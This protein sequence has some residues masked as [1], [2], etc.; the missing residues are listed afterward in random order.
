VRL[1]AARH[2][3]NVENELLRVQ[4]PGLHVCFQYDVSPA[5]GIQ[6]E[7]KIWQAAV[8]LE[9]ECLSPSCQIRDATQARAID[10][11][12]GDWTEKS[13]LD[14]ALFSEDG[15]LLKRRSTLLRLRASVF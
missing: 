15:L 14:G 1:P 5:R 3:F 4:V 8:R 2:S 6:P 9:L 10:L 7:Q 11:E 12:E 13:V